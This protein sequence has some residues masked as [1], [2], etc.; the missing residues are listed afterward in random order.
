MPRVHIVSRLQT[1]VANVIHDF[2]LAFTGCLRQEK[3]AVKRREQIDG[4]IV[5]DDRRGEH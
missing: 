3:H 5:L 4:T 1:C 2:M